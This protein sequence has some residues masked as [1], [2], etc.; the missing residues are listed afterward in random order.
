M[1]KLHAQFFHRIIDVTSFKEV[2]LAIDPTLQ[3]DRDRS[4]KHEALFD[5]QNSIKELRYY[6]EKLGLLDE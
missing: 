1:K 4:K 2:I 5:V 6:L 3:F